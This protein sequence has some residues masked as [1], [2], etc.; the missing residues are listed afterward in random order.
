[1]TDTERDALHK[2]ISVACTCKKRNT[3]EWMRYF[4]EC[5]NASLKALGS[6]S[7]VSYPG[8]WSNEFHF[9]IG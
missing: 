6:D 5:I 8:D 9:E 4:A 3:P 2:L 7:S 1:M